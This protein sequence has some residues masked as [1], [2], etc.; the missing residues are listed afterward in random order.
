MHELYYS[1]DEEGR[2]KHGAL[3]CL[4]CAT[5]SYATERPYPEATMY[6]AQRSQMRLAVRL[7]ACLELTAANSLTSQSARSYT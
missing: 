4:E 6:H 3:S 1:W 5:V 2:E 7:R